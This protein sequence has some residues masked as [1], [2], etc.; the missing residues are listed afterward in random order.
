VVRGY[1]GFCHHLLA[2]PGPDLGLWVFADPGLFVWFLSY[3]RARK[4]GREQVLKQISV[5]RKVADFLKAEARDDPDTDKHVARLDLWLQRLSAQ[6]SAT[7]P[8]AEMPAL[9]EHN[10]T[11]AWAAASL[12]KSLCLIRED[13]DVTGSISKRTAIFN[14]QA[15][16]VGWVVGIAMPPMRLDFIKN[17]PHPKFNGMGCQDPDCLHRLGS[18]WCPGNRLT[19]HGGG[20]GDLSPTESEEEAEEEER[21]RAGPSSHRD[22]PV[23]APGTVSIHVAHGKND[24]RSSKSSY[25]VNVRVTP[26]DFQICLLVHVRA[27][28]QLLTQESGDEGR[29]LLRLFVTTHAGRAFDDVTFNQFWHKAMRDTEAAVFGVGPFP[30]S[31]GRSSFVEAYTDLG[32]GAEPEFW[33]GAAAIMGNTTDQWRASYNPSHKQRAADATLA[34]Y[35]EFSK[36]RRIIPPGASG[37]PEGEGGAGAGGGTGSLPGWPR[38]RG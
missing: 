32:G 5:A 16:V 14:E 38:A 36:R 4:V 11:R 34:A 29:S 7:M 1:L 30:P 12:A 15:V 8:V 18:R 2:V 31:Q 26:S 21:E 13:L 9:P 17:V 22:C 20:L 23:L 10:K 19:V 25:N 37:R 3:L 24:R 33:E 28:R 27:G 6:I 35:S